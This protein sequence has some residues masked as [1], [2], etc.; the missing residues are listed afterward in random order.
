M[1]AKSI[2]A[3]FSV[4][5]LGGFSTAIAAPAETATNDTAAEAATTKTM[6]VFIVT[7]AGG[8]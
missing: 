6:K 3:A 4:V 1:K 2:F 5:A 8:G 7:A